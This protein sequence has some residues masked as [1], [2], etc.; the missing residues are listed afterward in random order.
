MDRINAKFNFKIQYIKDKEYIVTY[1]LS[2]RQILNGMSFLKETMFDNI[3]GFYRDD[4]LFSI[5]FES[6]SKVSRNQE[7]ID[8]FST[9]VL[10]VGI[11]YYNSRIWATK[12]GS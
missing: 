11:L 4:R 12:G 8:K 10:D 6:L 5:P 2:R 7:E 9:Y 1:S 3:K